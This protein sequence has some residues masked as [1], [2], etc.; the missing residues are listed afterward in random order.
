MG[1][2]GS[3]ATIGTALGAPL[4]GAASD[5]HPSWRGFATVGAVGM[6]IGVSGLVLERR[7]PGPKSPA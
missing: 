4:A 3:A 5:I 1:W 7:G 6:V 2:Y